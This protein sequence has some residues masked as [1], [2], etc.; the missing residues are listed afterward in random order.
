MQDYQQQ[1][2][3]KDPELWE[4]AKKRAGFKRHFIVYAIVN[5]FLWVMWFY[6]GRHFHQNLYVPWP[7]WTTLGWGIGLAFHFAGAYIFPKVYSVEKEYQKLK[8]K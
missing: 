1:P 2:A 5:V 6:S 3:G 8:N 7:M 4:L